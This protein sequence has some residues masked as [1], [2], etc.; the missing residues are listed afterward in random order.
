MI[1][2]IRFAFLGGKI[3]LSNFQYVTKNTIIKIHRLSATL[4]WWNQKI[5]YKELWLHKYLSLERQALLY[6][7][8]KRFGAKP[9]KGR[10]VY[11]G[12]IADGVSPASVF[13]NSHD[14]NDRGKIPRGFGR[15]HQDSNGQFKHKS[16]DDLSFSESGR[17]SKEINVDKERPSGASKAGSSDPADAQDELLAAP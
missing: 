12:G 15:N 14:V 13:G 3:E 2:N 4:Q 5:R 6:K 8:Q 7:Q 10:G 1:G 11:S 16:N 17:V 9:F